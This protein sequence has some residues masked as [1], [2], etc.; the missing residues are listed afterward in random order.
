MWYLYSM[1]LTSVYTSVLIQQMTQTKYVGT[2]ENLADIVNQ[3]YIPMAFYKSSLMIDYKNSNNP[4]KNTIAKTHI[5]FKDDSE[6][7]R[8]VR[9]EYNE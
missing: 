4:V 6:A 8:Y 2:I 7:V 1:I 3:N 5:G 9:L